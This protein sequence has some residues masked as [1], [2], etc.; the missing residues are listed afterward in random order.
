MIIV[1]TNIISE[2]MRLEPA[3]AVVDWFNTANPDALWTTSVVT[4]E[5]RFGLESMPAGKRRSALTGAFEEMLEM[6]FADRILDFDEAASQ[7]TASLMAQRKLS[8]ITIDLR[9]SM[10][11]GAALSRRAALATR[12]VKHFADI[13]IQIVNP[14]EKPQDS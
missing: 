11:A 9:D 10:I 3:A 5:M 1:D 4:M 14:F 13:A 6:M 2:L 8:G 7:V 12:N